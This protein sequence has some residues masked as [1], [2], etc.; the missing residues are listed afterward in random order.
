M[1]DFTSGVKGCTW[2]SK[3]KGYIFSLPVSVWNNKS[4]WN[5]HHVTVYEFSRASRI[6]Q[7]LGL[8][9]II[10]SVA[11]C[12]VPIRGPGSLRNSSQMYLC[13]QI[14]S[15]SSLS[16]TIIFLTLFK[17]WSA[18]HSFRDSYWLSKRIRHAKHKLNLSS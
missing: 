11:L 17:L 6:V 3:K 16:Q 9:P 4:T 7:T 1:W 18:L 13:I 14:V 8:S 12:M 2:N 10:F 5:K 15:Q